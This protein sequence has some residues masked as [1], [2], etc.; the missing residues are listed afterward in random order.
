MSEKKLSKETIQELFEERTQEEAKR[1]CGIGQ[2]TSCYTCDHANKQPAM[3]KPFGKSDKCPLSSYNVTPD[4]RTY[5]ER[6]EAGEAF[7]SPQEE[8]EATFA[9]CA[10]CKH[11]GVVEKDNC[12]ELSRIEESYNDF[13]LDCPVHLIQEGIQEVM[14]EAAMG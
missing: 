4:T 12:Y 5:K 8:L 9:V 11:A 1:I 3:F 13:C 6:L 14:A 7:I 10:C 2:C